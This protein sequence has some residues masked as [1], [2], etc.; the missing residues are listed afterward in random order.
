MNR[1]TWIAGG[2]LVLLVAVFATGWFSK[3]KSA[4]TSGGGGATNVKVDAALAGEGEGMASSQGCT[5]C[6]S[7]DGAPSVGPTWSGLY[8]S[9]IELDSGETVKADDAYLEQAIL[10]PGSQVQ[11]GFSAGMPSYQGKLSD[12]EV[13]ALVEYI[14]SLAG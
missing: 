13:A 6:H 8:G 2:L 11:A 3:D 14:K 7:T 4:T 10:D 5:S 12:Q 1:M 9:E